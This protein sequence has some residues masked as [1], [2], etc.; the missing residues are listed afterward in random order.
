MANFLADLRAVRHAS[1]SSLGDLAS[2]ISFTHHGGKRTF[3]TAAACR[4]ETGSRSVRSR[5]GRI[6]VGLAISKFGDALNIPVRSS[7]TD[8][9]LRAEIRRLARIVRGRARRANK[10]L[11]KLAREV[12]EVGS[13]G[14]TF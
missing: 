4:Y 6:Y 13:L 10:R 12:A 9:E 1:K 14:S 5:G 11:E 7:G 2:A 8:T 3:S